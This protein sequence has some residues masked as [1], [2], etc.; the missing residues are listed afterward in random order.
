MP[1]LVDSKSIWC[2]LEVAA[3]ELG[4]STRRARILLAQGRLLGEKSDGQ[5]RVNYPIRLIEGRRGPKLLSKG[6]QRPP[7]MPKRSGGIETA[8]S[9]VDGAPQAFTRSSAKMPQMHP[10]TD[11]VLRG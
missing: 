10:S 9:T 8:V 6:G 1:Q 5:W 4:I 2:R 3:Q 11:K 7:C